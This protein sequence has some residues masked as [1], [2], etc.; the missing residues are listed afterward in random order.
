ME[1]LE[2]TYKNYTL[3]RASKGRF[4][5]WAKVKKKKI[6]PVTKKATGGY[7]IVDDNFGYD[8]V[9]ESCIRDIIEMELDRKHKVLTLKEYLQEFKKE[10]KIIEE[11]LK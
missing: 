9:I 1:K 2:V 10:R 8:M 3:K 11:M 6:H 7:H 5:L 4:D